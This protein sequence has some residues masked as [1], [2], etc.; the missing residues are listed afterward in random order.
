LGNGFCLKMP[1]MTDRDR[2]GA[3]PAHLR[4]VSSPDRG[5]EGHWPESER[6]VFAV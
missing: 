5:P 3:T 1:A 2:L 6:A 4:T